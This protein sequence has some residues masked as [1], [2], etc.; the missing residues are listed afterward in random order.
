MMNYMSS[1]WSRICA[2]KS[3]TS[4]FYVTMKVRK[5][6]APVYNLGTHDLYRH[7]ILEQDLRAYSHQAK[8]KGE[9]KVE[10]FEERAER[11]KE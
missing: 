1:S 5:L 7:S 11:N 3:I 8:A 6:S 10:T 9:A 4:L 2:Q